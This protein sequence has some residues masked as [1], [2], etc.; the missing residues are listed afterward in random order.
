MT[1]K[2]KSDPFELENVRFEGI[3]NELRKAI[4]DRGIEILDCPTTPIPADLED[5]EEVIIIRECEE[6]T[7]DSYDLTYTLL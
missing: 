6:E 5:S 1:L 2:K 7:G 4:E 3:S